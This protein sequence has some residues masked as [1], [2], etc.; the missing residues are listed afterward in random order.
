MWVISA[1]PCDFFSLFELQYSPCENLGLLFL[2]L[3]LSSSF[4]S[5][6][7][8]QWGKTKC[9]KQLPR[10]LFNFFLVVLVYSHHSFL[11]HFVHSDLLLSVIHDISP[12]IISPLTHFSPNCKKD[13]A[14]IF[15]IWSGIKAEEWGT[16]LHCKNQV[17]FICLNVLM[18]MLH[19]QFFTRT[20]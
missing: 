12:F 4:Y 5:P 2:T 19:L 6:P 15:C 9:S 13:Y 3:S 10:S 1:H 11:T 14:H 20:T 18:Y 7:L 17:Y 8:R 16:F